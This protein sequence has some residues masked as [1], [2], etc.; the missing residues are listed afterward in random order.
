M[1]TGSK[2]G[3]RGALVPDATN[4]ESHSSE[5]SRLPLDRICSAHKAA[6]PATC[7]VAMLVPLIVARPPPAFAD[8]ISTPGAEMFAPVFEKLGTL[9]PPGLRSR[10]ATE[11]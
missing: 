11:T 8:V 7:G 5:L 1:E 6:T 10:A 9:Y 4:L 2:P 3:S